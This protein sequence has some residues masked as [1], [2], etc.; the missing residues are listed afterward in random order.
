MIPRQFGQ[1][2]ETAKSVLSILRVVLKLLTRPENR[3]LGATAEPLRIKQ[4]SQIVVTENAHIELHHQVD[5]FARVRTVTNQITEAND[6]RGALLLGVCQ[7]G[8]QCLKI[9][10]NVAYD[11]SLHTDASLLDCGSTMPDFSQRYCE[12]R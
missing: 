8:R 3:S 6:L 4:R 7:N 12:I 5:T 9:A 11:C 1:K 2:I 10:M